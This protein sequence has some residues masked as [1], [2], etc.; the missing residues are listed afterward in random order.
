L[1]ESTISPGAGLTGGCEPL[2]VAARNSA[3]LLYKG[4]KNFYQQSISP[5]TT[6]WPLGTGNNTAL[7]ESKTVSLF[8]RSGISTKTIKVKREYTSPVS[9]NRAAQ[10]ILQESGSKGKYEKITLC[11]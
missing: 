10:Q 4:I 2:T 3:P 6:H 9:E 5:M 1:E 11:S 8:K 7:V